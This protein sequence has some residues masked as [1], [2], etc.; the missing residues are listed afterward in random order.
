MLPHYQMRGGLAR[1]ASVLRL[2][3]SLGHPQRPRTAPG[4]GALI[5]DAINRDA[6][7][8]PDNPYHSGPLC[9]ALATRS[10]GESA[11]GERLLPH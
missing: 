1:G 4:G 11:A 9:R 6:V 10:G 7:P 2:D 5:T 3:K 8:T